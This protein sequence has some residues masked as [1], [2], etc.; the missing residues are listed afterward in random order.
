M[1]IETLD[2]GLSDEWRLKDT[3]GQTFLELWKDVI[4]RVKWPS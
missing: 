3:G 4:A 1:E 2:E